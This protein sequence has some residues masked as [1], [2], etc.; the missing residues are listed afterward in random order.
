MSAARDAAWLAAI[1]S[2]DRA[3][4]LSDSR[5]THRLGCE[6]AALPDDVAAALQHKEDERV[7]ILRAL[8]LSS[9]HEDE[10]QTE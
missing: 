1:N 8:E 2:V 10:Q 7:A 6:L 9:D 4:S 3:Y 5:A